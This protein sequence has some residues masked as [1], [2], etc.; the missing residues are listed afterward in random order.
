MVN[1]RSLI[2]SISIIFLLVGCNNES[3][4][5]LQ[6]EV[7]SL[8][9]EINSLKDKN[10]STPLDIVIND[11]KFENDKERFVISLTNATGNNYAFD[12]YYVN[13][14]G[15]SEIIIPKV[16]G[17][18]SPSGKQFELEVSIRDNYEQLIIRVYEFDTGRVN[19]LVLDN[20]S[21]I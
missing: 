10:K 14:N 16:K 6:K 17:I 19:Q 1:L 5:E 9:S 3:D 15:K 18:S 7:K 21:D 13:Q 2:V 20:P 11:T 4:T 12:V 8:R